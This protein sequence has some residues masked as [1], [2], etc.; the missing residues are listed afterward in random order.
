[1]AAGAV[2][3]AERPSDVLTLIREQVRG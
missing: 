3:V 1:M 2:A